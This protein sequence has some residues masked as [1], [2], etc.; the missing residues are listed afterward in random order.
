LESKL[1]PELHRSECFSPPK[2]EISSIVS[3]RYANPI[4]LSKSLKESNI[5]EEEEESES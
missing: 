1:N 5:Q 3:H 2:S 4:N